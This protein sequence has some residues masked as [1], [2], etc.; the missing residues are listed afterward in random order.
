MNLKKNVPAQAQAQAHAYQHPTVLCSAPATPSPT[1]RRLIRNARNRSSPSRQNLAAA[2]PFS[3]LA[4]A[5]SLV[6]RTADFVNRQPPRRDAHPR[7]REKRL[8]ITTANDLHE[9]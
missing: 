9:L 3:T 7:R 4:P 5:R 1:P 2:D 6:P 8:S